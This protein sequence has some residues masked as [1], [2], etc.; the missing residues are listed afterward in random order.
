MNKFI[1]PKCLSFENIEEEFTKYFESH[2][3]E[4]LSLA[5]QTRFLKSSEVHF[6]QCFFKDL[7]ATLT[8]ETKHKMDQYLKSEADYVSFSMIKGN[9]P[10]LNLKSI[11]NEISLLIFFKSF[12]LLEIFAKSFD[13]KLFKKYHDRVVSQSPSHLI[14]YKADQ[15]YALLASFLYHKTRI[16]LDNLATLLIKLINRMKSKAEKHVKEYATREVRRV[17]GKFDILLTLADTALQNP[18]NTIEEKIY[19]AVSVSQLKA[20]VDD[21][22][23]KEN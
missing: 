21:L 15:R 7:C 1:F 3:I 5:Q 12:E 16:C 17:N 8:D 10:Y 22:Q 11:E 6:E 4:A 2:K 14:R 13:N 9:N 23:Y 20:L 19:K 18:K